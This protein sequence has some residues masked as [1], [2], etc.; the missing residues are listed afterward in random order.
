MPHCDNPPLFITLASWDEDVRCDV[1]VQGN[2]TTKPGSQDVKMIG[3]MNE[4]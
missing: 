2:A 1:V 4:P 3:E